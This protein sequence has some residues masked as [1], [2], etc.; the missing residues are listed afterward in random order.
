MADR[1]AWTDGLLHVGE[2]MITT[3]NVVSIYD[4]PEKVRSSF[5]RT[6]LLFHIYRR[7]IKKV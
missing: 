1:L 4:G 5:R 2:I 3:Q 6:C 7:T